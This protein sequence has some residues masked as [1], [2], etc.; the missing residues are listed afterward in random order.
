MCDIKLNEIQ[1]EQISLNIRD[2]KVINTAIRA[3]LY[4]C[5]I[6][7]NYQTKPSNDK[8]DDFRHL[9][10]ASLCTYLATNDNGLLKYAPIIHPELK[11]LSIEDILN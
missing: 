3:N 1:A 7:R 6:A 8:N 10:D 9:I 5:F 11:L 2:F 4:M